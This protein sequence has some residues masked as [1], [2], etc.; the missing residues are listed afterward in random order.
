M[1]LAQRACQKTVSA[2]SS[3]KLF[4]LFYHSETV[5]LYWGILKNHEQVFDTSGGTEVVWIRFGLVPVRRNG[6]RAVRSPEGQDAWFENKQV[7]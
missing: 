4:S 6:S 3:A 5:S 2:F 7:Q 1:T